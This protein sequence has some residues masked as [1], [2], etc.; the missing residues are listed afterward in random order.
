VNSPYFNIW[1]MSVVKHNQLTERIGLQFR[2]DAF[3]VF[4]HRQFTLGTLS[5]FGSTVNSLSQSYANLTGG[6]AFL[7]PSLFN[8]GSRTVQLG[9]KITY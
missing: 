3:D 2:V 7:N 9:L 8:G 6:A 5:I 4:N 1:N